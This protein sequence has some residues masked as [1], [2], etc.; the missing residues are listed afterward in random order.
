VGKHIVKEVVEGQATTLEMEMEVVIKDLTLEKQLLQDTRECIL[1]RYVGWSV[2][3]FY[4]HIGFVI[5]VCLLVVNTYSNS[6]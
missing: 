4:L 6:L 3:G 1:L 5:L 2:V